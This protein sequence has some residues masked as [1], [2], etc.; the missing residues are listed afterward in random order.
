MQPIQTLTRALRSLLTLVE[1]E[2]SRNADFAQQLEAIVSDLPSPAAGRKSQ[3][4]TAPDSP[5]PDVLAAYEA[6][7]EDEF[8]F[9]LRE[10]DLATLKAIIKANGFDPGKNSQ[11]WSEPDKYIGLIAEQTAARLR[12]GSAFLP[13]KGGDSQASPS[14]H[15]L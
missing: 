13:P 12:R 11:R 14:P 4:P 10:H 1:E 7:G 8:R 9:W 5:P 2:A 6:K 15:L 3:K